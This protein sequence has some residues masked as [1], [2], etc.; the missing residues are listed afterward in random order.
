MTVP[1]LSF[2]A[3]ACSVGSTLWS[4]AR[5]RYDQAPLPLE[6]L[7]RQA[8]PAKKSTNILRLASGL[9]LVVAFVA[10]YVDDPKEMKSALVLVAAAVILI[11]QWAQYYVQRVRALEG[12]IKLSVP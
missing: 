5:L 3:I 2:I 1:I 12:I 4:L 6:F 10:D 8:R 7:A 9:C 11:S